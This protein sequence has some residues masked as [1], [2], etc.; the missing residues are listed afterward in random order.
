MKALCVLLVLFLGS[1]L[2]ECNAAE[3]HPAC[4][5]GLAPRSTV[6]PKLPPRLHN[7][8][9][10]KAQVEFVISPSGQVQSPVIASAEWRPIGHHNI[11]PIG[12]DEA[13]LL[14]V[15]LWVYP[16]QQH[17]CRHQAPVEFKWD[18]SSGPTAGRPNN[19]FKPNPLRGPA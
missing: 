13:I 6:A 11:K 18:D 2:C 1:T 16:P 17:A 5:P 15:A 4:S 8:F 14:A 7:E 19:S 9:V 3:L 10:G 12:Y